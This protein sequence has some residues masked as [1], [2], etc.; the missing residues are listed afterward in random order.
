MFW[1]SNY[2]SDFLGKITLFIF[3]EVIAFYIIKQCNF[4]FKGHFLKLTHL[5]GIDTLQKQKLLI[6]LLYLKV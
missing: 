1:L 2:Y 6:Q 3:K 5:S 4:V